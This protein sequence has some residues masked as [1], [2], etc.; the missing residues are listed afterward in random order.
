MITQPTVPHIVLVDDD[1]TLGLLTQEYLSSRGV[2]VSFCRSAA[3][4]WEVFRGQSVDLFILDVKM[5]LKN[6]FALAREIRAIDESVPIFFLT[7]DKAQESKLEGFYA[8]AD[9]YI[10]KPFSLEELWLRV[11]VA[12]K[13]SGKVPVSD[14]Q[15]ESE[16]WH[17]GRYRFYP[18]KRM[19]VLGD[20]PGV[21]LTA[22]EARLLDYFC[23]A[24]DGVIDRDT[25]LRRIWR[26]DDNLRGRSLNVYVSRL[27][28]YLAADP[29]IEIL[30]IH[31][32]G[33]RLVIPELEEGEA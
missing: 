28:Q 10:T 2:R 21:K 29:R 15:P 8:G 33:Y 26:D 12:L 20:E 14:K 32:E 22:I 5:P 19:L 24:R 27:R 23:Q 16:L 18:A 31:G 4:A 13:R 11:Q 25:A 7:G 3:V 1:Q 9:D 6:G 30:N 17:I